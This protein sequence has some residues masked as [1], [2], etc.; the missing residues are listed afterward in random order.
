MVD[1]TSLDRT[2]GV[3]KERDR[4]AEVR[5]ALESGRVEARKPEV[6]GMAVWDVIGWADMDATETADEG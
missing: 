5:A 2:R 4:A 3:T 1:A 6:D